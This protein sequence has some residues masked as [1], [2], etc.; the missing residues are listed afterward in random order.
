[1]CLCSLPALCHPVAV[2]ANIGIDVNVQDYNGD[3]CLHDAARFS[4]L[5]IA[6]II[7]DTGKANLSV[8]NNA[9]M[10]PAALARDHGH[11]EMAEFLSGAGARL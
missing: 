1:M 4:H 2:S 5:N 9:G 10:T 11:A 6:K 8:V 3:T 7:V